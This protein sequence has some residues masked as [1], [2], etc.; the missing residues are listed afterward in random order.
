[1]SLTV[2]TSTKVLGLV[3]SYVAY[4]SRLQNV[5]SD[6]LNYQQYSPIHNLSFSINSGF[7]SIFHGITGF[8]IGNSYNSALS[9][10][11][12]YN[13]NNFTI[14]ISASTSIQFMSYSYLGVNG[15][16]CSLCQGYN[17]YFANS[18]LA[19]CPANT[20]L[21]GQTCLSCSNTQYWN[22]TQCV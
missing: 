22:G 11:S 19:A 10:D 20:Y 13:S 9:L 1:M 8:I 3:V 17:I 7:R 21:N 15:N 6:I 4:D 14:G 12:V 2:T 18:C 5:Q 16:V